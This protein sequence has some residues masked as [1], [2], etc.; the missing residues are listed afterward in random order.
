MVVKIDKYAINMNFTQ[1]ESGYSGMETITLSNDT[2]EISLDLKGIE[3]NSLK[4]NDADWKYQFND[5]KDKLIIGELNTGKNK[6]DISFK[7][8]FSDSLSG[9]YLA[10]AGA[11]RI[12]TTQFESTDAS[13]AFPCF[14]NPETKAIFEITMQI[15]GD[16]EAISNMPVKSTRMDGETKIVEFLPTPVM[17]TYLLYMGVGKFKTKTVKYKKVEITM[18]IPGDEFTSNDFPLETASKCLKFYEN[19]FGIPFELPKVHLISVPD[20]AAGAMENWGAITFREEVLVCNDNTDLDSKIRIA[21]V[22]AHEL[23]HQWFGNLVTMKWWNDLW[24]NESFATFM[25]MLCLNSINPE[26]E[27]IKSS[28]SSDT[29]PSMASDSLKST[30]PINAKVD[31]PDDI[32]QIFDEISYGKGGSILKMIHDYVGYENFRKGV[33][34]YLTKFKYRNAEGSDLWNSIGEASGLPV[35]E[36][37]SDWINQPGLPVI[38][39]TKSGTKLKLEQERYF[40]NGQSSDQLWKIPL[41][42]KGTKEVKNVLMDTKTMEIGKGYF[43]KLNSDGNGFFRVIYDEEFYSTLKKKLKSF[44]DIDRAEIAN[45]SYSFFLSGKISADQFFGILNDL[46]LDTT[47]PVISLVQENLNNALSIL[48]DKEKFRNNALEMLRSILTALGE[49]SNDEETLKTITR[50]KIRETLSIYD[51]GFATKNAAKFDEYFSTPPGERQALALSKATTSSEIEPLKSMYAKAADDTDRNKLIIAMGSMKDKK[52]QKALMK[53]VMNG[54]VK[55][56]DSPWAFLSLLRN[57]HSRKYMLGIFKYV[58][59]AIRK[60]FAGSNFGSQAMQF[61]LPLLGLE[62]EKKT[63]KLAKLLNGPD[64]Y[65]GTSKGLELLDINLKFRKNN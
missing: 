14:D 32:A 28:Y 62:N 22:I 18:A 23:A 35:G 36:I 6:L 54:E 2:S 24:L 64:T 5:K 13:K 21:V 4:I 51:P 41:A 44:S 3:I 47:T 25:E 27:I 46:V 57:P 10:G 58:M 31:S 37:M 8:T 34:T 9:L 26:Y 17:S 52:N 1:G 53:M 42:I 30:H 61:A 60:E 12:I 16:K 63:R 65:L 33:S 48:F 43:V 7:R 50:E 55:R 20:F 59:K 56:Q 40:V 45:D 11:K 38:R 19:Y 15:P 39:V 29:V 49:K